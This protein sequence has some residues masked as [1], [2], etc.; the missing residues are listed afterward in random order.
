MCCIGMCKMLGFNMLPT[1]YSHFFCCLH[2]LN[3]YSALEFVSIWVS[4]PQG[5]ITE[6]QGLH[7]ATVS[8]EGQVYTLK[9]RRQIFLMWLLE[10]FP[11]TYGLATYIP[12]LLY[13]LMRLG[14]FKSTLH[15]NTHTIP[16]KHTPAHTPTKAYFKS[17]HNINL[18]SG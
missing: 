3:L 13:A 11:L 18:F 17:I 10:A 5:S 2:L 8:S 4:E 1:D 15:T 7:F 6:S 14:D 16:H 12:S 9:M